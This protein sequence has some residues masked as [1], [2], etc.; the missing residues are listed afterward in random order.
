MKKL[1]LRDKFGYGAAAVGD[2]ISYILITSFLMFFLTTVAGIQPAIAGTITVLGSV[3]NALINPVIG[4]LSDHC[5]SAW[6]RRRAY[7]FRF[8][9]P[10]FFVMVSL[11][12]VIEMPYAVKVLYYAFM[13]MAFWVSY[14][15]FFVP[16]YALGAEYTQDYE[17]RT[18]I[19]SFASFFNI[20]GTL[21]AMVMPTMSVEIMEH[22]G[23]K[24]SRAWMLTVV[25]LAAITI[26]SIIITIRNAKK[27]DV[28]VRIQVEFPRTSDKGLTY[29]E[30]ENNDRLNIKA[31]LCEFLELLRIK[32]V[33]TLIITSFLFLISY[34]IIMS[35]FIYFLSYNLCFDGHGISIVMLIRSAICIMLIPIVA[36]ICHITDKKKAMLIIFAVGVFGLV[37]MRCIP[38]KGGII[39]GIF[40]LI[41]GLSTM[42]YWQVMP[43]LY[44]DACEFV[45][46]ETGRKSEGAILS[47]QGLAEAISSGIGTQILGIILQFAGF[48]GDTAEQTETAMEWIFNCTTWVPAIFIVAAWMVLLRFPITRKTYNIDLN[49]D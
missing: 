2:A 4:Y 45:E 47:M 33:I 42:P 36:K 14:T 24:T 48:S 9:L 39:L 3:C 34:A 12:T 28:P 37:L 16:Y 10:L 35:N 46:H 7:M 31:M 26:I 13:T 20:I 41:N 1:T 44:Y 32:P 40:I 18:S 6:G 5:K 8:C 19:R 49:T 15:G 43:A 22:T 21:F 38:F 27:F 30:A 11:F 29:I 23:L 25:I 17:E